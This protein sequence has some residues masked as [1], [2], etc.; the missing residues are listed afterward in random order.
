MHTRH[1]ALT[2]LTGLALVLGGV[3]ACTEEDQRNAEER[4]EEGVKKGAEEVEQQVEEGAEEPSE[5]SPS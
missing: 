4:V 5:A 1:R 2:A 3:T